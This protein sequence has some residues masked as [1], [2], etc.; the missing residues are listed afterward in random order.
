[1]IYGAR[2]RNAPLQPR[3]LGVKP[4]WIRLRSQRLS[5]WHKL[6]V[7]RQALLPRALYGS[8][9][10]FLGFHWF[11]KLRSQIMRAL[12]F[13]RAG[14]NPIVRLAF[15]C[16]LSTDPFYVDAWKTFTCFVRVFQV[17][18]EVQRN[19]VAYM[20]DQPG[21][22]TFGPFAKFLLLLDFLDWRLV[23]RCESWHV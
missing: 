13:D 6:L 4:F 1:M 21:R 2:H 17:N 19:W 16:G 18:E 7:I 9:L 3:I 23:N 5:T 8:E 20:S 10:T 12:K 14:A 22:R 11:T 15:S